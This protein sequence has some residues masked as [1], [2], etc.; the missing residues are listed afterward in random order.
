M[1]L[2]GRLLGNRYEILE[3]VGNGGMATV[4]KA[5]CH[6]LN[7][8]VAVK[9]LR[10]EFTTDEE[11][12]KRF[13]TEAQA[14]AS[15]T[16]PNI[17]SVY[18]V[19]SEGDLHYIVMELIKGKTLK[20]IIKEDGAISWKWSVN[21]A[22][23]IASALETAH[24]NHIIH[25]DIKPHN[26]IITED[27][28][29]KVTDFGIAKAVSNS[30]ITAF[31][32][33]IGSV[34]YFSPEHARGGFTDPKSDLYS[35]GVV[36]YEMIT[37][38][39]PFNADTPVSVALKHMQETPKEPIEINP[40]IPKVVNDIVMKAMQKDVNLRYQTATEMLKDLSRAIKN[41]SED[42]VVMEKAENDFPTQRLST[43]YDKSEEKQEKREIGFMK[44]HKTLLITIGAI[45]LFAISILATNLILNATAKKDV[46]IPNLIGKEQSQAQSELKELKLE[47]VV[48][49]EG[50]SKDIPEGCIISQEPKYQENYTIK[51]GEII[52]VVLSKGR[53]IV[54]VPKVVGK[55]EEEAVKELEELGLIV[56]IPEENRE[57][58]KKVEAGYII[59]QDIAAKTEIDAGETIT[60]KVSKGVE[61]VIVPDLMGKTEDEAKSII[62]ENGLKLKYVYTD[63]NESKPDGVI[64]DQDLDAN[65]EVEKDSYINIWVNS[66]PTEKK[67]T[68]NVNLK[69]LLGA[70]Y[71]PKY[72][73]VLDE[74]GNPVLDENGQPTKKIKYVLVRIFVNNKDE[75]YKEEVDPRLE[76]VKVEF[77]NKGYVTIKVLVDGYNLKETGMDLEEETECIIDKAD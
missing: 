12:V 71:N 40:E 16:H 36:L 62:T 66:L 27:G 73:D 26:I 29:A 38:K 6:V 24:K 30:T 11:F 3:Q 18:D 15:L 42:F 53:N 1:N 67:A 28:I 45:V 37:G 5:K 58:N 59:E 54:K 14:A 76:S 70:G 41:P 20:E 51:E 17:V 64:I 69:S 44:K 2:E 22:I 7:R 63:I 31:G 75:I 23:Q 56:N 49:G 34:H 65:K 8:F 74:N 68:I 39:V 33:T 19:G 25:R 50:Y 52:T 61:M 13:N 21:V 55:T 35:L 43:I 4:Y 10:E 46:Q 48:G 57:Y 72:E 9:V 60:L 77:T 32:S 47:Y